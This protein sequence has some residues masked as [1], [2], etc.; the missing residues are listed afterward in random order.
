MAGNSLGTAY[1]QV[2]PKFEGGS[3]EKTGREAGQIFENGLGGA[4]K[5]VGSILAASAIVKGIYDIGKAALDAYADF[6]QLAGGVEVLYG[7]AAQTVMENANKAFR[8]AGL[9][10]N[11]YMEQSTSM[12][13]ALLNSLGGDAE[14][15]AR[16]ADMAIVDMADNAN[17]MGSD[18]A[19][20]Q[21]AYQGF[22]KQ[23]YTMLD[24]LKL[25]YGGTK[26]EMERLLADAEAISG[27]HYDIENY[28]DVV[29]AIHVIQE[30]MGVA[31]ATAEEAASTISGSWGMLSSAWQNLLVSIA[32]GGEELDVAIRNVVESL[33]TWLGNVVPRVGEVI[34]G[35]MQALPGIIADALPDVTSAVMGFIR[36]TF[37]SD[38]ADTV[39]DWVNQIHGVFTRL[40]E[41]FSEYV[42]AVETYLLPSFQGIIDAVAPIIADVVPKLME[43]FETVAGGVI[44][45][46]T[47]AVEWV[48]QAIEYVTPIIETVLQTVTNVFSG[49][50]TI[51]E[52]VVKFVTSLVKG[53][54]EGMADAVGTIFGGIRETASSI[55]NGISDIIGSVVE[56]IKT[57]ASDAWESV[58]STASTVWEG[59]KS[60]IQSPI[61]S[62]KEIVRNAIDAIKG[63]F[64][65]KFE[66][67]HIPLPHFSISGSANPLDWITGGLPQIGIS[68]YAKGGFVES[69][70]LIGAGERGAE[71]IWPEY[72]PYF[73]RYA[74]ALAEH[75]AGAGTVNNYYIDGSAVAADAR[76][77]AALEVIARRVE[78]R[79]RMGVAY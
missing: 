41:K 79:R 54:F 38:T 45:L 31:G 1:V 43:S 23:N 51:I 24:N 44:D 13:A 74:A 62:A 77:S 52:G 28:D 69:P 46:A 12:A 53:D 29:E 37:G 25:G 64:S 71:M 4:L 58:R 8:T 15:A 6:E 2:V 3:I 30:E 63:F 65:F 7:D 5:K 19:S 68:W 39:L 40:G 67:P 32:G 18:L 78:G 49:I 73:S 61:E 36:D 21:S 57:V 20:I 56:T 10:A 59:V 17:R 9:S 76:L 48:S 72:E 75:M 50:K 70:T 55:W 14:E 22:A 47:V 60:A 26:T 27:I 11:A 42:A 66:W 33:F 34:V 35:M 16:M